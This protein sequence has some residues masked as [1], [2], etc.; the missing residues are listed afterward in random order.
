MYIEEK[1]IQRACRKACPNEYKDTEAYGDL[2]EYES[3]ELFRYEKVRE[4]LRDGSSR[5]SKIAIPAEH[6]MAIYVN[7]RKRMEVTCTGQY[8][9]ELILGRLLTEGFIGDAG[10][11]ES[12]RV[13]ES[14]KIGEVTLKVKDQSRQQASECMPS[15]IKPVKWEKEW[16][17]ALADRMAEGMPLHQ[18]TFAVHSCFLSIGGELLFECEDI[19]RHNA[20]DKVIGY[21]LRSQ[22]DLRRCIVYSSGRIPADMAIKA[23]RAGIPVLAAKA[24]PTQEAVELAR[25]YGLTLICSARRDMLKQ[26]V[27]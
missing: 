6:L 5:E 12:V 16:V 14:G 20:F 3:L 23:V 19:G 18:K 26:F 11:V 25:E 10:D 4:I 8:L 13:N 27:C 22:V 15:V 2:S 1:Y 21:A 9:A 24:V 7:G 17:F